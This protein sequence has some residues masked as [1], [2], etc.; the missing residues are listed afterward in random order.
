MWPSMQGK[1]AYP[2]PTVSSFY[3]T[4]PPSPP[5]TTIGLGGHWAE[6]GTAHRV[7]NKQTSTNAKSECESLRQLVIEQDKACSTPIDAFLQ[8]QEHKLDPQ[9]TKGNGPVLPCGR[10]GKTDDDVMCVV[11]PS[12]RMQTR[13][14]MHHATYTC[15]LIGPH[16][17]R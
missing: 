12:G 13:A 11:R 3:P 4:N 7:V 1:Q 15:D 10:T 6:A 16:L 2:T 8:G 5:H 14:C 17:H 9:P